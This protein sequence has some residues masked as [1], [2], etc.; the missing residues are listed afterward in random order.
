MSVLVAYPFLLLDSLEDFWVIRK[1]VLV[2]QI[3]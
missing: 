1:V 3:G 2:F